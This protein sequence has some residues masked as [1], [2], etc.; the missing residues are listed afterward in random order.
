MHTIIIKWI[1]GLINILIIIKYPETM[2]EVI[3]G[4]SSYKTPF[5]NYYID[6][7][8]HISD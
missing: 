6:R 1:Y 2:R 4:G 3:I 7:E 5:T 8:K